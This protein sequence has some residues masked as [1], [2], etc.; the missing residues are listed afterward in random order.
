MRTF[1]LICLTIGALAGLAAVI[2][3][4]LSLQQ[5]SSG[6]RD[7]RTKKWQ[8]VVIYSHIE[9]AGESGITF[10]GLRSKYLESVQQFSEFDL[11]KEQISDETLRWIILDLI[12]GRVINILPDFKYRANFEP[13]FF[14][15]PMASLAPIYFQAQ[16]RA[17]FYVTTEPNKYDRIQLGKKLAV[18]IPGLTDVQIEMQLQ[19]ITLDGVFQENEDGKLSIG[20][21]HNPGRLPIPLR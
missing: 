1:K 8:S 5:L 2:G 13:A 15:D 9:K 18:E 7:E 3:S 21:S 16:E 17:F 11:P 10:D 4:A 14:R 12:S 6:Y 20:T 19:R